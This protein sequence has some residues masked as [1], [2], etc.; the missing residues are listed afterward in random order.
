MGMKHRWITTKK[1]T[2]CYFC[3]LKLADHRSELNADCHRRWSPTHGLMGQG[4]LLNRARH[5][6][7]K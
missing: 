2:I 6:T 1:G 4:R 3:K 5:W 7:G